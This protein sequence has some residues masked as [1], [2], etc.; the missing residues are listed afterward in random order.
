MLTEL[1]FQQLQKEFDENLKNQNKF[2]KSYMLLFETL[3]LFIRA[4]RQQLWKLH[5]K[6]SHYLCP[7]F[8]VFDTLNYARLTPIYLSQMYQLR[9][10]DPAIWNRFVEGEFS[11]SK[12][13][14]PFSAIGADDALEQES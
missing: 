14:V 13:N 1:N 8:F 7:Y 2:Y 11:V 12:S 10:D 3:L 9:N 4:S 6:S 5:L